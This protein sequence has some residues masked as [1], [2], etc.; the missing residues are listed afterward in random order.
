MSITIRAAAPEAR[1]RAPGD[2]QPI[3]VRW[4]LVAATCA[5]ASGAP[6]AA[7]QE[8]ADGPSAG[9][10]GEDVRPVEPDPRTPQGSAL[11]FLV[12]CREGDYER[13]ADFLDLSR[14][15]P[16]RRAERGPALARD[17]KV[18]LDR[19]LWVPV[20]ALSGD[21]AGDR[22]DGLAADLEKLGEIESARGAVPV[23]LERVVR[24][25][26][27]VWLFS[28]GTVARIP[29]LYEEHGYGPLDR[30]L[31]APF[32]ELRMLEI[33][34]WQWLALLVV[35]LLAWM[36]SYGAARGL[37]R[38]LRPL[39]ERTESDLDDRLFESA[40]PPLRLLLAVAFFWAGSL[41]LAL[42]VPAQEALGAA[43][44][45]LVLVGFAWL[46]MRLVDVA[47]A[48][49]E[50]RLAEH[51]QAAAVPLVGPG[52]KVAK[53]ALGAVAF[54]AVLDNFGFNVTALVAGLGVGGIAVALAAQKSIENLFGGVM[55][56]ADS[57]ARV[58]DF[59]RWS[60][61]VGTVEEIGMRSTRI[62][63]LDRTVI[64]VP[65]AEFSNLQIENFTRRDSMRLYTVI[66]V[67]YETTPEQLRHV[68]V[69]VR[70]LL[71]AHP[72]ISPD[73]A[74]IRFVGFGAYSLD[75]EIFAYVTTT[76]W[77]EFL[78]VREDVF[79][80]VMDAIDASGTGFAFPS[81]TL[82]LGRDEGLDAERAREAEARVAEWRERG[83]LYI[84]RFPDP[85]I[86]EFAGSHPWPPDGSPDAP[87]R[88]GW[89]EKGGD[90]R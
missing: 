85:V 79:L 81:Q 4:L 89:V 58:G 60:G 39:V 17:L 63:T 43:E 23:L 11:G 47:A 65:N 35:V 51:G 34:L 16:A 88:P 67:R 50:Q 14:I 75:L 20:E 13:A 18:V 41:A 78:Q 74:R 19:T 71:Y 68:L 80:S 30:W 25:G 42:S 10:S 56:Y 45:A 1:R 83:E 84:P 52:R 40:L 82:Y 2:L 46:V 15:E 38:V 29:A 66:G 54:V 36:L 62:R 49:I 61:Q 86:Q 87:R 26:E 24:D 90:P 32:F 27:R 77:N 69:E 31:P 21:P 6:P 9:P 7:A 72:K 22:D 55:L 70:K 48:V 12:A 3:W 28:A 59:C 73:P 76:D 64:T 57:P 37:V 44:R 8:P 33:V 5:L 53:F